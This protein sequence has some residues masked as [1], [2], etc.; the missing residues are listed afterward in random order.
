MQKSEKTLKNSTFFFERDYTY[1]SPLKWLKIGQKQ[2]KNS[3]F[4]VFQKYTP[5]KVHIF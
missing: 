4:K 3:V 5:K 2:A 1:P